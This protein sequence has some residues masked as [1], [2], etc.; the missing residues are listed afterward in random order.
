MSQVTFDPQY[1][2]T[3]GPS[4][5]TLMSSLFEESRGRRRSIPVKFVVDSIGEIQV[6]IN[7]IEREDGTGESW[8]FT[9]YFVKDDKSYTGKVK[10]Y[11]QTTRRRGCIFFEK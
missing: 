10:G 2:V 4:K 7:S 3:D 11:F 9:G 5:F 1:S 6:F 8:N